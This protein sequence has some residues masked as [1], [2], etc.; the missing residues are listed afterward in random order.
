MGWTSNPRPAGILKNNTSPPMLKKH[1]YAIACCIALTAAHGCQEKQ[2][3][4]SWQTSAMPIRCNV[5]SVDDMSSNR[6]LIETND[7]LNQIGLTKGEAIALWGD[8]TFNGEVH[9]DFI[10]TP[11]TCTAAENNTWNYHDYTRYWRDHAQYKFRAFFPMNAI[12]D[13]A[14]AA[15][16]ESLNI[17]YDTETLQED[18]LVAYR[19]IDTDSWNQQRA[20]PLEM[21]HALATLKFVFKMEEASKR[22][23]SLTSLH[24]DKQLKTAGQL[25]YN[26]TQVTVESWQNLKTSGAGQLYAWA[27]SG[28]SFSATTQATAYTTPQG[29]TTTTGAE[30][31]VSNGHLFIIPQEC[32]VAPT[33]SLST[34]TKE[35]DVSLGTTRFQPGKQYIY[36]LTVRDD[37]E[38]HITLKIKKWNELDSSYDITF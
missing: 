38:L 32:A 17:D 33:L 36:T 14:Q 25:V 34:P 13:K 2:E 24:L 35:Y 5:S 3:E 30:Y 22:T 8:F 9:H 6:S 29:T 7:Q 12:G 37:D 31:C 20:V 21:Q 1:L 23:N 10:N 19:E 26:T 16:A 27:N 11:L 4:N 15:D 28:V 18:L